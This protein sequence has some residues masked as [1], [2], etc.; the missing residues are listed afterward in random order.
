MICE[1]PC[2]ARAMPG[3]SF[4]ESTIADRAEVHR[5][6]LLPKAHWLRSAGLELF[7]KRDRHQHRS[8]RPAR[9]DVISP[10]RLHVHGTGVAIG[11]VFASVEDRTYSLIDGHT[12]GAGC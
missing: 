11:E 2:Y 1:F 3:G 6:P 9:W 12:H 5:G 4:G 10:G 8:A 7:E